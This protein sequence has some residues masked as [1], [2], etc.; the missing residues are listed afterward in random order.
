MPLSPRATGAVALLAAFSVTTL[1]ACGSGSSPPPD[2][3][4]G[5]F[6]GRVA[7]PGGRALYLECRGAGRP[8]VI[9]E[10]GLRNRADIW[11]VAGDDDNSPDAVFPKL[12]GF[13]RVCAYDRP[14][15]TLGS[16]QFSR[17]DPVPM[18]RSAADAVND[19]HQLLA[20]TRV[21]GPYVMVGHS[22]GGLIARLYAATHPDQVVGLVLVDAIAETMQTRL[23][24]EQWAEYDRLLLVAPPPALAGYRDLETIDFDVSFAQMRAAA[25]AR[26]LPPLPFAV[27]SKG[28]PFALPPDLPTWLADAVERAWRSSQDWLAALLPDTRHV[29]V[30]DSSHYIQVERP[31]VVIDA[32]EQVVD[33]VRNYRPVERRGE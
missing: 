8:T 33:A 7:L 18:P 9:L 14:G 23:T 27:L 11:R 19:L 32:V 25:V 12:A 30:A 1:S 26:P 21:P 31:Q 5:D 10:A 17:S 13:T 20:A 22:T 29:V 6:A 3:R 2:G 4:R 15:T 16:D 28:Q 24:P